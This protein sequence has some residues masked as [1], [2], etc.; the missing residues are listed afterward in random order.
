MQSLC[1][2]RKRVSLGEK[3]PDKTI[4]LIEFSGKNAGMGDIVISVQQY[5]RLAYQ[6]GWYPVINLTEENQYI[7]HIGDN[8]W[9]YYFMQ[10]SDISVEDALKSKNVIRGSENHFGVLPWLANPLCNM[11]DA[12]KEK[13]QLNHE[14]LVSF[15]TDMP[16]EFSFP[17]IK[18][19]VSNK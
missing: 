19:A 6:R 8:M 2:A 17:K 11:N 4:L 16:K 7:S 14:T 10:P 3:N 15:E 13:I 5:I 18:V 12:L 9:D 1:W